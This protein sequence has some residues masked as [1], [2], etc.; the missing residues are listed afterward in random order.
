MINKIL[1]LALKNTTTIEL[2]ERKSDSNVKNIN[3]KNQVF[4]I[5]FHNQG[6]QFRF[7]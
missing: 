7:A 4:K 3:P 2:C 6:I 1:R 5:K